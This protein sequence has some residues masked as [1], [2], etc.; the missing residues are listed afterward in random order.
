MDPS[1]SMPDP[2][3]LPR[4]ALLQAAAATTGVVLLGFTL[5]LPRAR[6]A[7]PQALF[8]P[9]AFIRIEHNG[10]ITL[11]CPQAEMGQGIYTAI[12][13]ILADELGVSLEQVDL[14]PAPPSDALYG[15]PVF[16]IQV[17]GNSNSV[18]AFWTPLR[19]AAAGARSMLITA[20][21]QRWNVPAQSCRA[22]DGVVHSG[23]H[24]A[25]YAELAVAAS[26]VAPPKSPQLK[27]RAEF[28]LIGHPLKRLDTAGKVNGNAVFAIDVLPPGVKF[29]TLKVCPVFGGKVRRVDDR[30]AKALPG[31][32]QVVVLE[33]LVAVVGDHMWAAKQGL[34]ALQIDWDEGEFAQLS[35]ADIWKQLRDASTQEGVVAKS[36]GDAEAAL[37]GATTLEA[38]FEMPFLAHTTMEPMNCTV[39]VTSDACELWVGSQVQ[40]RAHAT[41]AKVCGLPPE[42]VTLHQQLLGGGFGR[43]L[44]VDFVDKAV[45]IAR[46]VDTPVKVVWSRE[47]DLRQDIFRPVYRDLLQAR[48]ADGRIRALKYR[49]SGS[50]IIAR[51]LPPA[52]Q[53]GIDIDAI[54]SAADMPYDIPDLRV[55]Y[56]RV[57]PPG[58][59]TGFWRGVGPNNNV[60]AI[61]S[62]VDELARSAS[63]DP[64]EFRR[65]MLDKQPRLK[66]ALEL[67]ASKSGWGQALPAR[68]GRGAAIQVSFG[69]YIATV[70]EVE[71]ERSGA[72][73]VRRIV[74]AVDT[75]IVVNP[76]T[77]VAQL[78]GGL[79]FGTTA[80]LY[81]EVTVERGRPQQSN[82]NNYR[83]LRI[84]E[85]PQIEV[86]LIDSDEPPGGIGETGT[87]A[88]VPAI[89]NAIYAATGIR[90]RRMPIDRRALASS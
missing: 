89:A 4:R 49:V 44:E 50:S 41:A 51:W 82:F 53:H 1:S 85:T 55:E 60:F 33:D 70:A 63:V 76:D 18:R 68:S 5:P 36:V 75:G 52:F 67:A 66:A 27:S 81:S 10:R 72:V 48:L 43:R 59:P 45:R 56:V 6:A 7:Q 69:S 90:L 11:I 35:S 23:G 78:Q 12:A 22:A 64:V 16:R 2:V 86:Y 21:A 46:H 28:T 32:R 30:Q 73:H 24:Q 3:S 40:S 83:M 29:A 62:F 37:R 58:V 80:A 74:S 17:T 26:K 47:E 25:S 20:A 39:H 38:A 8:A 13:M 65:R 87:T 61:E 88:A 79:I 57:E 19:M 15:N 34:E 77:V 54:D 9:N 71:V 42:K 14:E 84:D 31:V